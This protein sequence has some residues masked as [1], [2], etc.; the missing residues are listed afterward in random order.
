MITT[1]QIKELR[2]KTGVSI[3]QCKNAL[4]EAGGDM[5]KAAI[6]LNKKSGK[7]AEK[8]SGRTLAAGVV[9]S[10]IHAGGS[11]GSMLELLCETDFVAKNEE[12]KSLAYDLAMHITAT[13]PAFLK[14]E[15][16][17]EEDRAKV[18][19]VFAKEVAELPEKAGQTDDLK[20]KILQG[21][22]DAYFKEKI[23]LEQVYIKDQDRTINNLIESAIQKFGERIELGRFV[24]FSIN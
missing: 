16:V 21:K 20:D 3:M 18:K 10:Y 12:F 5:E 8:K 19:E 17:S 24:R 1:E 7:I 4:E 15:D 13:N 14:K 6:I 11:V 2:N 22:L 9:Q 23:L